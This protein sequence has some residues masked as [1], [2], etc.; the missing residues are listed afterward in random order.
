M[1]PDE[2][3]LLPVRP[4]VELTYR[5]VYEGIVGTSWGVTSRVRDDSRDGGHEEFEESR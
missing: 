1:S 3:R 2:I 5:D 4:L